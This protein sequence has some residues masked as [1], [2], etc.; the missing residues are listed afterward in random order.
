VTIPSNAY[1]SLK[2]RLAAVTPKTFMPHTAGTCALAQTRDGAL[3]RQCQP[4]TPQPRKHTSTARAQYRQARNTL[5]IK[6]TPKPPTG[7]S[8]LVQSRTD[9]GHAVTPAGVG[10]RIQKSTN[11]KG[12]KAHQRD[13]SCHTTYGRCASPTSRFGNKAIIIFACQCHAAAAHGPGSTPHRL[14]YIAS[15]HT[16]PA[17]REEPWLPKG[18]TP[19][20]VKARG[21][22]GCGQVRNQ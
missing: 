18:V 21:E 11:Q 8:G 7:A 2:R 16:F 3:W 5:K 19:L 13:R 22:S 12:L 9:A 6:R 15:H 17:A 4:H 14:H 1:S 20:T 10:L